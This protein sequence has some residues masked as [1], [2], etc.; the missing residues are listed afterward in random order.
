M[1]IIK[2]Q[3]WDIYRAKVF[4]EDTDTY[5]PRP[6]LMLDEINNIY[7]ALKITS[8]TKRMGLDEYNIKYWKEAGLIEPSNIRLSK[9]LIIKENLILK[10]YGK[11]HIIDRKNLIAQLRN[12][13]LVYNVHYSK[14][15][16]DK[17]EKRIDE[18]L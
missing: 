17:L 13:I 2:P 14:D 4:F 1:N 6:I 10:Q 9:F 16:I 8:N 3:V 5:E 18:N 15:I 11:L 7:F 12:L